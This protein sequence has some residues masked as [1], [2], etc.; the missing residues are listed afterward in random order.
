[1]NQNLEV[2]V[3]RSDLEYSA[4]GLNDPGAIAVVMIVSSVWDP[5]GDPLQ[6]YANMLHKLQQSYTVAA[7]VKKP[8]RYRLVPDGAGSYRRL[9]ETRRVLNV[10]TP[11]ATIVVELYWDEDQGPPP[12]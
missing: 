2:D 3:Y 6:V 8:N 10:S 4:S 12:N 5:L 7:V 9:C 1:M 11:G